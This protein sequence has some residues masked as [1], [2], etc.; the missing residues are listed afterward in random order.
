ML[1]CSWDS[2]SWFYFSTSARKPDVLVGGFIFRVLF[3]L[4]QLPLLRLESQV[5]SNFYLRRREMPFL[6][7]LARRE[8]QTAS[9]LFW[10]WLVEFISYDDN[11]YVTSSSIKTRCKKTKTKTKKRKIGVFFTNCLSYLCY[12]VVWLLQ[13]HFP[14]TFSIIFEQFLLESWSWIELE[15]VL[16][17]QKPFHKQQK[18]NKVVCFILL[19]FL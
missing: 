13:Y 4:D 9:S 16:L 15:T 7:E 3:L 8:I 2:G 11:R 14:F 6:R 12:C 10:T 19:F 18:I 5:Y 1:T 17:I